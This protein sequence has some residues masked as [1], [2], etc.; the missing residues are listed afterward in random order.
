MIRYPCNCIT[1]THLSHSFSRLVLPA[2]P[3]PPFILSSP[4]I[5][6]LFLGVFLRI[7]SQPPVTGYPVGY[8]CVGYFS[9][10]IIFVEQKTATVYFLLQRVF[11]FV[12][13]ILCIFSFLTFKFFVESKITDL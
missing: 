11:V 10:W 4:H 3:S 7:R 5:L 13:C 2:S 9:F 12:T 6:F 1:T 8:K